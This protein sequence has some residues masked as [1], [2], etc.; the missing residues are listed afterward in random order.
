MKSCEAI[1]TLKTYNK[2]MVQ[3]YD[4]YSHGEDVTTKYTG[5]IEDYNNYLEINAK[6]LKELMSN[7][8][9]V[10]NIY[11]DLIGDLELVYD[12]AITFNTSVVKALSLI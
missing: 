11:I 4:N 2:A 10:R 7:S 3:L 5:I 1:N 8:R 6:A 12:T 9:E